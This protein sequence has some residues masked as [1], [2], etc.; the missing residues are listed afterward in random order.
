MSRSRVLSQFKPHHITV[1]HAPVQQQYSVN[2]GYFVL[3]LFR[4][5]TLYLARLLVAL[6]VTTLRLDLRLLVLW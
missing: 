2:A 1:L 6:A 5:N 3:E 4:L